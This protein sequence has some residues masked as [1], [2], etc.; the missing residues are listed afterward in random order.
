M[1]EKTYTVADALVA[2]SETLG[3]LSEALSLQAGALRLLAEGLPPV[4]LKP[5]KPAKPAAPVAS[6]PVASVQVAD[7]VPFD[8]APAPAEDPE[9]APAQEVTLAELRVIFAEKSKA[10][11]KAEL[12]AILEAHGAT[13]LPDLKPEEFAE[14]AAKVRAL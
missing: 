7:D 13:K 3:T 11:F 5:A 14:V 2:L 8:L 1:T 12:I 6:V 9:P 10:G 4:E